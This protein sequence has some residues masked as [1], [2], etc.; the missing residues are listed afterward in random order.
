MR[1]RV[2]FCIQNIEEF[3][4]LRAIDDKEVKNQLEAIFIRFLLAKGL[5]FKVNLEIDIVEKLTKERNEEISYII[6]EK[7]LESINH[8]LAKGAKS[9]DITDLFDIR[10]F[11][12][13]GEQENSPDGR[14]KVMIIEKSLD[15]IELMSPNYG[16]DCQK[17][18]IDGEEMG[19]Y[20]E[21][22]SKLSSEP[23]EE[24][25]KRLFLALAASPCSGCFTA[26]LNASIFN[27]L[28]HPKFIERGSEFVL[29]VIKNQ[30]I[31][32]I[33]DTEAFKSLE[34][35]IRDCESVVNPELVI[36]SIS[37]FW[38][39]LESHKISKHFAVK[40]S[41]VFAENILLPDGLSNDLCEIIERYGDS[42]MELAV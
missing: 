25:N 20:V 28:H 41:K 23:A 17:Y 13:F 34:S 29:S 40:L 42:E 18:V 19:L 36:P 16:P 14:A 4:K 37:R 10:H 22:I 1:E 3:N 6:K 35:F 26:F 32:N 5:G 11:C 38:S 12:Q 31:Q 30:S 39:I 27:I 2:F 24:I 15:F 9:L 21:Y 33:D 8:L 7:D